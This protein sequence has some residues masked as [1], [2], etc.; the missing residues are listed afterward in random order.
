MSI[1]VRESAGKGKRYRAEVRIKRDGAIVHQEYKTFRSRPLAVKWRDKRRSELKGKTEFTR[2]TVADAIDEYVEKYEKI[3]QWGRTKRTT[4][5]FLR[6][7]IGNWDATTVT[8]GDMVRHITQRRAEGASG[9]TA[10]ND[11][12]WLTV[13][14]KAMRAIERPVA[15]QALE[16]AQ[17]VCKQQGL[18]GRARR[19]ERRPT[20]NELE[21][22]ANHFNHKDEYSELPMCDIILFAIHSSRRQAEIT[23]LKWA[24]NDPN[25][26]TGM[27]RDL[28]HPRKKIGNNR[29][30][31]YTQEAFD[32]IERQPRVSE[33]IFPYNAKTIGTYFTKACNILEIE[34][35]RFHDLRHEATSRLFEKGYSIVEVQ[36]FTLHE[37]WGVLKRYTNLRPE[38]V[39]LR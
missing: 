21:L 36:Q 3:Q 12:I 28:K 4:L 2:Y 16:D 18:I 17:L 9:S 33:F 15:L 11:L 23:R 30:F 10:G 22:L 32:I 27:V 7:R 19:R 6:K 14:F 24:D 39:T 34:D 31:K 26:L 1:T 29:R 35:L 38:N 13:V 20:E 8:S 5:E 37:D 25:T